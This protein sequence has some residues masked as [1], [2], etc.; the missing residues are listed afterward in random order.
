VAPSPAEKL[1]RKHINLDQEDDQI[2]TFIRSL[3][4]DPDG[5]VLE[6]GGEAIVRVLPPNGP[7]YDPALLE[8]AIL[9]RRDASRAETAEWAEADH[10]VWN[11]LE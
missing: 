3:P 6:L 7:A 11:E 10:E 1:A 4:I 8:Q 2:K 5:S 9:R